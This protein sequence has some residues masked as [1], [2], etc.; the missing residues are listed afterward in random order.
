[1]VLI[2]ASSPALFPL[3]DPGSLAAL[4]CALCAEQTAVPGGTRNGF[5]AV[6]SSSA[7]AFLIFHPES[8]GEAGLCS[9]VQ[10][11]TPPRM[12]MREM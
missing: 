8:H 3:V 9:G 7:S 6:L 2:W 12:K 1:M 5:L 10:D 11:T 4:F